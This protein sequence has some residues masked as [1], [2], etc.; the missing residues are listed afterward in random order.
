MQRWLSDRE[1]W[2]SL[3][4]IIAWFPA[5][6]WQFTTVT[7]GSMKLDRSLGTKISLFGG[8]LPGCLSGG[9]EQ[10]P[11]GKHLVNSERTG[12][13]GRRGE[14]EPGDSSLGVGMGL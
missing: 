5:L 8:R 14:G 6:T 12:R 7:K 10:Q 9:T 13:D 1:H 2:A 4:E 3:L 11:A